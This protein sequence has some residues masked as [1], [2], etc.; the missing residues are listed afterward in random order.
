MR[1]RVSKCSCLFLL[2]ILINNALAQTFTA[3][4]SN[5][6]TV[7]AGNQVTVAYSA[8]ANFGAGNQV[9]VELS[10]AAGGFTSPVVLNTANTTAASGSYN[11]T[12]PAATAGSNF[13]RIRVRSTNPANTFLVGTIFTIVSQ[14]QCACPGNFKV[15]WQASFGGNATDNFSVVVPTADGG[16]L[17]GGQ[18]NSSANTGNK[19][20]LAYNGSFSYWVVKVDAAG[21][22]LWDSTYGGNNSDILQKIIPTPDGGY[23]LCGLSLSDQNTGNKTSARRGS[24]STDCWVIKINADGVKQWEQ[25]YGGSEINSIFDAV[26]TADGGYFLAGQSNSP[27]SGTKT[28]PLRVEMDYWLVKI[29]GNGNQLWDSTYGGTNIDQLR[30]IAATPDGGFILAGRSRSLANGTK[31]VS[32]NVGGVFDYYVVKINANGQQQWDN[33]YGGT[34]SDDLSHIIPATDGNYLLVGHSASA[35]ATGQKTAPLIGVSDIWVVKIDGSGTQLWDSTYGGAGAETNTSIM[36]NRDGGF[37][38][39]AQSA[40]GATGNKTLASFGSNDLWVLKIDGNG[41]MSEQYAYGSA[42]NDNMSNNHQIW[43]TTDGGFIIGGSSAGGLTGIKTVPTNGLDDYWI[44][45]VSPNIQ[46][47]A[48]A[49]TSTVC[50]GNELTIDYSTSCGTFNS[51]NNIRIELSNAAGSFASPTLLNTAATT[52][53]SGSYNVTIPSATAGGEFYR[54]R[55][56]STNPVDTFIIGYVFTIVPEIQCNCPGNFKIDWQGSYGGNAVENFRV[57][58]PTAD[59]GYLLGG[60]SLSSQ[61]TGNKTSPS[62]GDNDFWIVK[63]DAAGNNLWDSTYGGNSNDLLWSIIPTPDGGF[64]LGGES[65]SAAGTGNKTATLHGQQD[66]WVVK[67]NAN[68][69]RQWDQSYGGTSGDILFAITPTADGNY[70]LAGLSNSGINGNKTTPNIGN[71]DFWVVKIDVNGNPLW[72]R[73]YGGTAND[74]LRNIVPL[75]DGGFLLGGRSVSAIG[76]TKTVASNAVNVFDYYVVKIDA[77]GTQVWDNVYGGTSADLFSRIIPTTDGG[78]LL[79]GSSLSGATGQ[80]TTPSIGS[81]DWWV[82]K[83]DANGIKQWDSTYG[84]TGADLSPGIVPSSDGGFYI[85]G[86]SGSQNT[87]NKSLPSFGSN[88]YWV[89]KIAGDGAINEQYVYGSTITDVIQYGFQLWPTSDGGFIVG[90]QSAGPVGGNK[91]VA[92]N[93]SGVVDYWII[94]VSPNI[95]LSATARTSTVCAGNELTIDYSTSC[96]TFNSGNNIRI[97]LSNAAGSFASPVLLNTAATTANSG[98]Y[99]VTIPSATPGGEFY[100]IRVISTNPVDTA[101]I[102]KLFTIVPPALCNCSNDLISIWQASYGGTG[103]EDPQ[104]IFP[105][106]DGGYLFGGWSPSAPGGNKTSPAYGSSHFWLVKTD[107]NGTIQWDSSYGGDNSELLRVII[108]A[109]DGGYILGGQTSTIVA[110]GNLTTPTFASNDYWIVKINTNGVIEW[111]QSFGGNNQDNFY[112]IVPTSDGGYLLGG[113][114]NSLA[115]GSR[116]AASFGNTDFWVVKVDGNGN[117]IWDKAY[118]GSENDFMRSILPTSDGGYLLTGHSTSNIGGL[119]SENRNSS[120]PAQADYWVVKI[121]ADGNFQWDKT[122]GGE[123]SDQLRSAISLADGNFLLVGASSSPTPSA[124]GQKTAPHYSGSDIWVVKIDPSGNILWDNAFGGSASD[125]PSSIVQLG[126]GSIAINSF[127]N[128]PVSGNKTLANFGGN[129]SWL[130]FI[131]TAGNKLN[132]SIWGGTGGDNARTL[133]P[134]SDGGLLLLNQSLSAP[135]GT[136]TINTNGGNDYWVVKLG[137]NVQLSATARTTTICAGESLT[138]DYANIG[139]GNIG[140]GNNIRIELSNAAGSFASPLLLNSAATTANSGNYN[141]TIPSATPGGEFYKIRVISTNPMDTVIIGKL[142]TIVSQVDCSCP[143][144]LIIDWQISEGGSTGDIL[145]VIL[146]TADGGYL[147]G[148]RSQSAGATGT[149][150]S[151]NYGNYDYWLVKIDANGTKLWD[152]SYGGSEFD[153]IWSILPTADGGYLI[154]GYSSSPANGNKI[155]A[156]NGQQDY[157][158]IKINADG[159]RQW[160]RSYGGTSIDLFTSMTAT[161]DGSFLLSGYSISGVNGTKTA[162]G[163]GNYDYW[164]LKID[165]NGNQ[166]WDKTYGGSGADMFPQIIPAADGGFLVGGYS[167]SPADGTK[168]RPSLDADYWVVKIDAEGTQLWDSIYGGSSAETLNKMVLTADG[169]FLLGGYSNSIPSGQKTS[170]NRGS[171][172]Y[173]LVK[174]N[175]NGTQLWD[176]TY[177]GNGNDDLYDL[178]PAKDGDFYLSGQSNSPANGNKTRPSLGSADYWVVKVNANGVKTKEY[179]YGGTSLDQQ[180]AIYPTSNGGFLIGGFTSSGIGGNKTVNTNGNVDY[181]IL[182]VSPPPKITPVNINASS[183]CTGDS[184]NIE[185]DIND[186]GNFNSANVFTYQLSDTLGSFAAPTI[187]G[188]APNTTNGDTTLALPLS[189][190]TGSSY[191]IRIVAS[192]PVIISDTTTAFSINSTPDLSAGISASCNNG[193]VISVPDQGSGATYQWQNNAVN[194]LTATNREFAPI[195]QGVYRVIAS[196]GTCRDTA[197]T[198]SIIYATANGRKFITL[199]D[200]ADRLICDSLTTHVIMRLDDDVD[201]KPH[202]NTSTNMYVVPSTPTY[203]GQPYVRRYWDVTPPAPKDKPAT[204]TF[205]VTQADFNDFNTNAIGWPPLP[206][207]PAD[208]AGIGNLVVSVFHGNSATNLPATYN[209][210]AEYKLSGASVTVNW[211]AGINL[212][213]ISLPVDSFSGFFVHT[214]PA[215]L[216]VTLVKF[217]G[218]FHE[219]VPGVLLNWETAAERDCDYFIVEKLMDNG[220]YNAIGNVPCFGNSNIPREYIFTDINFNNGS[221][222]YRLKQVDYN[223]QFEYSKSIDVPVILPDRFNFKAWTDQVFI[224]TEVSEEGQINILDNQGRIVRSFPVIAGQRVQLFAANWPSG[225]YLVN[226]TNDNNQQT[227]KVILQR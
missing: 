116:T 220:Q 48:T 80:K 184:I 147:L 47:S 218:S 61:N 214:V 185:F 43:P 172:D 128:S 120:N 219:E 212:W 83:I 213:E 66:F 11:V 5:T 54:I 181:W 159:V 71:A 35:A 6:T 216:P 139:C 49:R 142:F 39:A 206:T 144:D 33:R 221:N 135:S 196:R 64:L 108:P 92:P 225:L 87:G 38:I 65:Q 129:E 158:M 75:P 215:V 176:S 208:A 111:Q 99:N 9:I 27:V 13:Y 63:V 56:L 23:L 58:V 73:T 114:S 105:T 8:S 187:L 123:A 7:C 155:A 118:G 132:E 62:Y 193:L 22:K 67:I 170:I 4:T 177:G 102:G 107:A 188:T 210:R 89:L 19:T 46:L 2:L 104:V 151:L 126:N 224:Y 122:I 137:G 110:S 140:A 50:A 69:V 205:Y 15:D 117:K 78:F 12:I 74:Q 113:E 18:S 143:D 180:R 112:S 162:P 79:T 183:F 103:A 26:P 91:T 161:A 168:T 40:S 30:S 14:A 60:I 175:A 152:S 57:V 17:L 197:G 72:D 166:L 125:D 226:F 173:W 96:G 97:E 41:V 227:Q 207:G 119:K 42:A 59:G 131:D 44:I 141:V 31:T 136:K 84:G 82:V 21:T 203:N 127:T 202:T 200:G 154:G 124:I 109:H 20:S 52:A 81:D 190:P 51:G 156:T 192:N 145:N 77:S 55:V 148:G 1:C 86:Q 45:K 179:I 174:I 194:I 3:A 93:V 150:A 198:Y 94:K 138:I 199:P 157:W 178:I 153:E 211:N 201:S 88:D 32:A 164:V 24:A 222:I 98:S 95:Q 16:Y 146:P 160:E 133:Y 171:N 10:N 28:A 130:V 217:T 195:A 70:L 76:G 191:R 163:N 115:I 149:K 68:G 189:L 167:S 34:G 169:G 223:G 106:P 134:T 186:C 204:M 101:V 85:A 182:K 36:P 53:A 90:G 165:A 121:D 100:K 25:S 37:Y 209:G 29:D